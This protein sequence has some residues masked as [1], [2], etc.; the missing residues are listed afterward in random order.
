MPVRK[1]PANR[2]SLTGLVASR[3]DGRM[4]ASESSLERDLLVLLDFDPAVE[5]YEEQPVRIEYRDARGRRRT[6]TPDV[7]VHFRQ[8]IAQGQPTPPL[9]YEVKYRRDLFENWREIKP[10]VRAGRAYARGRGWR[11]KII[12]EREIR[13]P[14]LQSVKFLRQYLRLQ[15]GEAERRLL[16]DRLREL[17]ESDPESLLLAIHREPVKRAELL[18]TL[19]HLVAAGEI[20]A[21]LARPLNMRSPIR[22]AADV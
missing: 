18:P 14:Y 2:R 21:D 7:L 12:T 1:I 4:A 8:D 5:R 17:G 19:W 20:H 10:K 3:R 22:V 13:T 11:F 16:L 9:L 6:Y 15:P